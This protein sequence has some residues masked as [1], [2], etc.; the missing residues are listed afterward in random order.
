M[1]SVPTFSPNPYAN[2]D[3]SQW[4]NPYSSFQNSGI[5]FPAS[6]SGWPTDSMGNPI[7][8][9]SA[10]PGLTPGQTS[11]PSTPATAAPAS[12]PGTTLNSMPATGPPP[13]VSP[14]TGDPNNPGVTYASERAMT[15]QAQ[16][17]AFIN[18]LPGPQFNGRGGGD[19]QAAN[20]TNANLGRYT[21]SLAPRQ[22]QMSLRLQF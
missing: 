15:P 8:A 2:F 6:Y 13:G 17:Q 7:G 19:S 4:T 20:T 11:L 5:P 14:Y 22:M 21:S 1:V 12:T 18:Q 3:P 16:A 9:T 10:T